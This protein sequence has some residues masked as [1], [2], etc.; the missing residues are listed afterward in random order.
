VNEIKITK[1]SYVE[2]AYEVRT[3]KKSSSE[4]LI[5]YLSKYHL[6]SSKHHY[7]LSWCEIHKIRLSLSYKSID[8]TNKLILLKN[9]M[10]TL[11]TQY[12][13][14]SLNRFYTV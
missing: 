14:D 8:G 1:E 13:W 3:S 5:V 10:N 6:F 9:S 2:L 7:F 12:N 11:K 4:K